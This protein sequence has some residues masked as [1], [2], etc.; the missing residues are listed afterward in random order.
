MSGADPRPHAR[1]ATDAAARDRWPPP[2]AVPFGRVG[3]VVPPG[4]GAYR[5]ALHPALRFDGDRREAVS[6]ADVVA[7]LGREIT[8][9]DDW[10]DLDGDLV[11]VVDQVPDEGRLPREVAEPLIEVL[12][13]ATTTPTRWWIGVWDGYG[14]ISGGGARIP[15]GQRTRWARRRARRAAGRWRRER[16]SYA[17][18]AGSAALIDDWSDGAR[19][20]RLF[21]GGPDA[22]LAFG[23][24]GEGPNLW[25]PDD[26]AW[27][28]ATD[29]DLPWTYVGASA[30]TIDE[31]ERRTWLEL[32]HVTPD[33]DVAEVRPP[34]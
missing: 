32:R 17:R 4:F 12:H 20:F 22:V 28:V 14:S 25:W 10:R 2:R 19:R 26:G 18:W 11:R 24:R 21:R 30:S 31:L 33:E 15:L 34:S 7:E 1:P 23:D 3:S 13:D 8:H 6:W 9:P 27:C 5:S 16:D 29:V